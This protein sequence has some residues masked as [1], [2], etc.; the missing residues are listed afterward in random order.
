MANYLYSWWNGAE[1]TTNEPL[2]QNITDKVEKIIDF[3][4]SVLELEHK[5]ERMLLKFYSIEKG[6]EALQKLVDEKS[7]FS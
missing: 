5:V 6:L 4:K 1:Q 2:V 3:E 7:L